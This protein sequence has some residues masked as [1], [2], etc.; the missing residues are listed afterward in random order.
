MLIAIT[1]SAAPEGGAADGLRGLR[2]RGA[3]RA[4]GAAAQGAAGPALAGGRTQEL[5]ELGA[6][7]ERVGD[8]AAGLEREGG[9]DVS[10]GVREHDLAGQRASAVEGGET[11]EGGG[12]DGGG[13]AEDERGGHGRSVV[14]QTHKLK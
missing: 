13:G 6:L 9:A 10:A 3:R 11:C 1:V 4:L 5:D 12:V 14:A 2:Q 8:H 7:L